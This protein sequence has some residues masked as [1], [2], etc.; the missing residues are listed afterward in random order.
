[1]KHFETAL[2]LVPDSAIARIEYA[3]ALV[4]LF[5]QGKMDQAVK[6]YEKAATATP[7]DAMEYLDV[8]LAKA[9][10]ED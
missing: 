9:E 2:K 7:V 5:G 10:L 6:L 8:E 1:V 3:N 4:M